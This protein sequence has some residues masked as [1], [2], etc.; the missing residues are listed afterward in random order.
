MRTDQHTFLTFT[1][2]IIY[3]K[4]KIINIVKQKKWSIM[5]KTLKIIGI[6]LGVIAMIVIMF[7]EVAAFDGYIDSKVD[8]VQT[9]VQAPPTGITIPTNLGYSASTY[10]IELTATPDEF[11]DYFESVLAKDTINQIMISGQRMGNDTRKIK[12]A[13]VYNNY[14][15]MQ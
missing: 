9:A 8:K 10:C 1:I 13:I 11:K 4:I 12:W 2:K 6:T 5:K 15:P 7:F 14:K 3:S